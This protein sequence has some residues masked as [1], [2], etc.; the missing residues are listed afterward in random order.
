MGQKAIHIRL[1]RALLIPMIQCEIRQPITKKVC[2][3][4]MV[5]PAVI[6]TLL[7]LFLTWEFP[8]GQD[9]FGALGAINFGL[10]LTDFIY[11][12]YILKAPRHAYVEED[13]NGCKILIKQ[14]F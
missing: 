14:T 13:R 2:L 5:F 3:L 7:T 12:F 6:G 4:I 8:S 1:K 11:I 10:C 9:Y